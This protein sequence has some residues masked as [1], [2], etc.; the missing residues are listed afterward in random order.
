MNWFL[1]QT[2]A[3]GRCYV[4]ITTDKRWI[5]IDG[6]WA[7]DINQL[8]VSDLIKISRW[9]TLKPIRNPQEWRN[10]WIVLQD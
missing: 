9:N 6:K 2:Q 10:L 8:T 7:D 1:R 5:L 4:L 3:G